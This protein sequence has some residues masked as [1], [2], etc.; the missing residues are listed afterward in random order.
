MNF[1]KNRA[2]RLEE[3]LRQKSNYE[4]KM[5]RARYDRSKKS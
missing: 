4:E 5:M 2:D 1:H 3:L